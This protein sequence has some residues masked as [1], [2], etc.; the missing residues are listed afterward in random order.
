MNLPNKLTI[1][2][3][4]MVPVFVIT[5]MLTKVPVLES[6]SLVLFV[7]SAVVF[8]ASALTDMADGKIARK[9]NL[10]TNFGKFMD[11]LADK[12]MVIGALFASIYV[13]DAIRFELVVTTLIIVFRE[14]AVTGMRL[15]VV[16]ADNVVVPAAMAGK[17]KTFS[18]CILVEL[19]ILEPLIFGF[20]D[21]FV[22]YLPLTRICMLAVVFF[23]LY[24]GYQYLKAY[25]KY[26]TI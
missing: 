14:L 3:M 22:T 7:V 12:F 17:I 19:I 13:F 16:N 25:G 11:P 10:I 8:A 26:I 24:S 23:T 1:I 2:R 15:V 4:V 5:L 20:S 6:V 21:F 18:Q 9:Y